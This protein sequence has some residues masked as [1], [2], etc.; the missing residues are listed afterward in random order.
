MLKTVLSQV[1]ENQKRV[2]MVNALDDLGLN[3][4]I[5]DYDNYLSLPQDSGMKETYKQNLMS[6][7]ADYKNKKLTS[8]TQPLRD[9]SQQDNDGDNLQR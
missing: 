1:S 2:S 9:V 4:I 3:E 7:I 6:R 8:T 5:H